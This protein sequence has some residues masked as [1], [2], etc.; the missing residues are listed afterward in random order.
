MY[1]SFV[2]SRGAVCRNLDKM[3]GRYATMEKEYFKQYDK[4]TKLALEQKY[5]LSTPPLF[6][7]PTSPRNISSPDF[8]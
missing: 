1:F 6:T 4:S 8:Q 7:N 2:H 3:G 5:K